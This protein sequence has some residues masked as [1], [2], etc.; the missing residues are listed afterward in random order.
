MKESMPKVTRRVSSRGVRVL[1]V[2]TWASTIG[3]II[4]GSAVRVTDSGMG[5]KGWPLCTGAQGSIASFHP[6]M[7]ESHR[8]LASIVTVL[9]LLLAWSVRHCERARHL[10]GPSLVGVG[11]I[12]VQIVLGAVTVFAKNAPF[13]VALHL[14]TATLFLGVSSVLAV[15]AFISP[16][17]GWSLRTGTGPLAWA[18]VASLY[19]VIISGSVVVSA[20]A[21][22]A[23]AAWPLCLHS[24]AA[25]SLLL[26]QTAHR[27]MVLVASVL[28]VAFL[29]VQLRS[30][31]ASGGVR[32]VARLALV[33]LATQVVVGAMS[34]IWSS[35][36][37]VADVHLAVA[38]LLWSSVVAVLTLSASEPR[39]PEEVSRRRQA[40]RVRA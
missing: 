9:I 29:L 27:A 18:A 24:S 15:V 3:L 34:A 23:C 35:H 22:S 25:T 32:V 31:R 5:C 16:E 2:A 36:T 12:G 14:L 37:E 28:V 8:L 39:A 17:R 4:L 40:P 33:L 7:E 13:T 38:S 19:T 10:R 21:Q 26:V 11:V 20:G 30:K 1:A 6:V